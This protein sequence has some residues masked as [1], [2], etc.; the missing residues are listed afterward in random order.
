MTT[1]SKE[2]STAAF[3][4]AELNAN[5]KS[6]ESSQTQKKSGIVLQLQ[7]KVDTDSVNLSYTQR[8]SERVNKLIE[9]NNLISDL[10]IKDPTNGAY[11]PLADANEVHDI[12]KDLSRA[13]K[14]SG[15]KD[16]NG[17]SEIHSLDPARVADL[18]KD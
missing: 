13:I 17:L 8:R 2:I 5:S 11:L 10:N 12:L 1:E 4:L 6:Q 18:L 16:G 7:P 3:R 9:L 14:E 15:K